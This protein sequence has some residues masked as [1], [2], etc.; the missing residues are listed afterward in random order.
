MQLLHVLV[1]MLLLLLQ[2]RCGLCLLRG[3]L[4]CCVL[5]LVLVVVVVVM[6]MPLQLL[7][8]ELLIC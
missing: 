4:G 7:L 1:V 2:L 8:S 5:L 3:P 6:L